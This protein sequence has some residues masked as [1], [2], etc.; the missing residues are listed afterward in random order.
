M[1]RQESIGGTLEV[2]PPEVVGFLP[3]AQDVDLRIVCK[4]SRRK[5]ICRGQGRVWRAVP[6]VR[7]WELAYKGLF[8]LQEV[9]NKATLAQTPIPKT[10]PHSRNLNLQTPAPKPETPNPKL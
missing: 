7:V 5:R 4:S 9:K 6:G 2:C 8:R 1:E 10:L 3:G